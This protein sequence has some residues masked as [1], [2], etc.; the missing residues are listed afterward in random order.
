TLQRAGALAARDPIRWR[1]IAIVLTTVGAR[2]PAITA[3]QQALKIEPTH[4]ATRLALAGL[5]RDDHR[6]ADALALLAPLLEQA[7]AAVL[8]LHG[9]LCAD[10]GDYPTA[11]TSFAKAHR[12][13]PS[14]TG[15][16]L[17]FARS[18]SRAGRAAEGLVLARSCTHAAPAAPVAWL[19]RGLCA[20]DLAEAETSFRRALKLNPKYV[21]A[22]SQLARRLC[23]AGRATEAL[24]ELDAFLAHTPDNAEAH[25]SRGIVLERLDRLAE[26][27][28]A[29]GR[30][31]ALDPA[32]AEAKKGYN[33]CGHTLMDRA[34]ALL[35]AGD[36]TA[37]WAAYEWRRQSD[38]MQPHPYAQ[39]PDWPAGQPRHGHLLVW[40]EQGIGDEIM[41]TSLLPLLIP[42]VDRITLACNPRLQ[43]LFAR[44]FPAIVTI[45]QPTDPREPH[46]EVEADW[47]IP[48]GSIPARFWTSAPPPGLGQ[49]SLQPDPAQVAELRTRYGAE[50]RPLVGLS[51]FT[52]NARNGAERSIS[53][54][55]L[56][57]A[58]HGVPAQFVSLQ[59]GDTAAARAAAT[60]AGVD[61]ICDPQ[62]DT[63]NDL[64]GFAA[65]IAAMDAVLTI[66]NSTV[67]FAGAL[68]RPTWLL[69]PTP[70]DWRWRAEG[71]T[72]PWYPSV[73]IHRRSADSVWEPTIIR[74]LA[75][76]ATVLVRS[77][78]GDTP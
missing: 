44:S 31:V 73:N 68:G 46:P 12:L 53:P 6:T 2:A 15:L 49:V 32:H 66:D 75:E 59:Y 55:T 64:D 63:W 1:E 40:S 52:Q 21:E 4:R 36:F 71:D 16:A 18:C 77:H 48:I 62:L 35:H 11:T 50:R 33:A 29:Y 13:R 69:V 38:Q 67:H 8:R 72:T 26:A 74:A 41:F 51:W 20:E 56:F 17:E 54:D 3:L 27:Y 14:D 5:L 10:S 70:A 45:A 43:P 76:I 25:H 30:A 24:A 19:I 61:L 47:Q 23:E 39:L 34:L 37:G 58:C 28:A 7:D 57:A 65:Q 42:L 22:T 9:Q 78:P 60:A